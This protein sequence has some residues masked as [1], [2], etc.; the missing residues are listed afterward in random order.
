MTFAV[1]AKERRFYFCCVIVVALYKQSSQNLPIFF[2]ELDFTHISY[3][4]A[5][6]VVPTI[7]GNKQSKCSFNTKYLPNDSGCTVAMFHRL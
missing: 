7:A 3:H 4:F 5:I 1:N 2:K 6:L